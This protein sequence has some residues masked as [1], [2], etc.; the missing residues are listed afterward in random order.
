MNRRKPLHC[1]KRILGMGFHLVNALDKVVSKI[2]I[3]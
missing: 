2:F 3:R 1:G